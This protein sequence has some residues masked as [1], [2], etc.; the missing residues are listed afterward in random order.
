MKIVDRYLINRKQS[1]P[2]SKFYKEFR[3][4]HIKRY[5]Q[6]MHEGNSN[7]SNLLNIPVIKKNKSLQKLIPKDT[8]KY[9]DNRIKDLVES[10]TFSPRVAP[11]S[12]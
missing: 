12:H 2:L 4:D 10:Y 5:G 3:K 6:K 1:W 8:R 9:K 11:K 7:N